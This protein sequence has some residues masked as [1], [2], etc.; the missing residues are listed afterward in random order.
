[1]RISGGLSECSD[2]NEIVPQVP[3]DKYWGAQTQR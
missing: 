2:S 3:G 1:M